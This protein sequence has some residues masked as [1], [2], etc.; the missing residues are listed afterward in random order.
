VYLSHVNYKRDAYHDY[1]R[2]ICYVRGIIR[3]V[4]CSSFTMVD[5][6]HIVR[7]GVDAREI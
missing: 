7:C 3:F 5:C 1:S 4:S 6:F 2:K